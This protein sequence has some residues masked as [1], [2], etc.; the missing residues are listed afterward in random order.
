MA[1]NVLGPKAIKLV[2]DDLKS[3]KNSHLPFSISSDASNRGNIKLF[4]LVVTYF[5][6]NEGIKTKLLDFYSNDKES[7]QAITDKIRNILDDCG[8]TLFN[9]VS[10]S[11]DNAPVNYG[12]NNSVYQKLCS[13][14][15]FT[16][17]ANCS[18]HFIHTAAEH[19]CKKLS[20]DVENLINKVYSEF[21]TSTSCGREWKACFY[22]FRIEYKSILKNVTTR[23]LSLSKAVDR[24]ILTGQPASNTF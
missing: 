6:P 11:A 20:Y 14:N 18:C 23:W 4:P 9:V 7:F 2:L 12:E 3:D 8:L 17:K 16:I 21:S 15:P 24:V 5:V 10:Y 1:E 13:V 22:D 19:G